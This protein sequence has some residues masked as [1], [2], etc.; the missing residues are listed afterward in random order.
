MSISIPGDDTHMSHVANPSGTKKA[1]GDSSAGVDAAT[2][3]A[4]GEN[5]VINGMIDLSAIQMIE[6]STLS[7]LNN[8]SMSAVG[9]TQRSEKR[10]EK[11]NELALGMDTSKFQSSKV[12]SLGDI[13]CE[14]MVLMIQSTSERRQ[15]ERE[16]RSVLSVAQID[17][18]N[19]IAEEMKEKM[20]IDVERI[21]TSAWTQFAV[22]MA[23]TA[24]SIGGA[25]IQGAKMARSPGTMSA[26]GITRQ[27]QR[28]GEIKKI[29]SMAGEMG[30][31]FSDLDAIK[32]SAKLE[33]SIQRK[34]TALKLTRAVAASVETSLKS[35]DSTREQFMSTMSQIN[36]ALHDGAMQIIR[37][38]VI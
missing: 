4:V 21:K 14:L 20:K 32:A 3:K 7:H 17:Q 26:E 24:V 10:S 28:E 27:L 22:S 15:M 2:L 34:Q 35:I 19:K 37:N 31:A 36:Q 12:D 11:I 13:M 6:R 25:A 23:S 38:T 18:S 30:T 5:L 33:E 1:S 29:I 16:F 8:N 9:G